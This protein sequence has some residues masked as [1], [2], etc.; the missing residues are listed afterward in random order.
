MVNFQK[1]I[2]R[3]VALEE[4]PGP[5]KTSKMEHHATIVNG[6]K[7]LTTVTKLSIFDICGKPGY[8]LRVCAC[9][10]CTHWIQF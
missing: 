9:N 8:A 2:E 5:P 7:L 3:P 1:K 10:I 4:Y 6:Q